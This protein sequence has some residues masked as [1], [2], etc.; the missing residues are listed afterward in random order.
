M[1]TLY[2]KYSESRD[3]NIEQYE[4]MEKALDEAMYLIESGY[5]VKVEQE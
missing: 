3:W 4:T 1:V 2:S 5:I